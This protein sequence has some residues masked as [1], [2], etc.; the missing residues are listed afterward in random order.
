MGRDTRGSRGI[1]RAPF[2]ERL[3]YT[4][5]APAR[6]SA[7][8]TEAQLAAQKRHWKAAPATDGTTSWPQKPFVWFKLEVVLVVSDPETCCVTRMPDSDSSYH[9]ILSS[10]KQND[11]RICNVQN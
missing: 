11:S 2:I 7:R 5:H 1:I 8:P 9:T 3:G 4:S 6:L 10:G